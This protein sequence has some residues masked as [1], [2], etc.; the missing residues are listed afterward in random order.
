[1]A[2]TR[3]DAVKGMK[4]ILWCLLVAV[5]MG[6]VTAVVGGSYGNMVVVAV[7]TT[8]AFGAL[9]AIPMVILAVQGWI[10]IYD[11]LELFTIEYRPTMEQV[12]STLRRK[13]VFFKKACTREEIFL[14]QGL[15]QYKNCPPN[16]PDP[17]VSLQRVQAAWEGER[18][19]L[20][21]EVRRTRERFWELWHLA[22]GQGYD[23]AD[24]WKAYIPAEELDPVGGAP[25]CED[26]EG[27]NEPPG[28]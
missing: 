23:L 4:V 22:K 24:S 28:Q 27:R 15:V 26:Y 8:I 11:R 19:Q 21:K 14:R 17:E 20:A 25:S 1:M 16:H 7:G 18:A 5:A 9:L 3:S 13:A 2:K 12:T 6:I 10:V